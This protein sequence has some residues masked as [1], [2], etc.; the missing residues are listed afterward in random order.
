MDI[1]LY[2]REVSRKITKETQLLRLKN[3]KQWFHDD[4]L[5]L[6]I[7]RSLIGYELCV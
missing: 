2:V 3:A 7:C 1:M 5:C 4:L 6:K